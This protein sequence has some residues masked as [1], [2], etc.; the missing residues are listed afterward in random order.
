VLQVRATLQ[1]HAQTER[2]ENKV[3]PSVA[4][5]HFDGTV[6]STKGESESP[7]VVKVASIDASAFSESLQEELAFVC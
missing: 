4:K 3:A 5:L 2:E 6:V 1:S 7:E